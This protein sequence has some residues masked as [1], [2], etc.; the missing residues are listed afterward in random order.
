MDKQRK[1]ASIKIVINLP[2]NYYGPNFVYYETQ[3]ASKKKI[4]WAVEIFLANENKCII[5]I[6]YFMISFISL[7]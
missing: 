3:L 7:L 5:W 4:W 2:S 1:I 6:T